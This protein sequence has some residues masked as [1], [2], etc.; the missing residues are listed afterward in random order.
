LLLGGFNNLFI[1]SELPEEACLKGRLPLKPKKATLCIEPAEEIVVDADCPGTTE[2]KKI[3]A[4]GIPADGDQVSYII[5]ITVS[6]ETV[7]CDLEITGGD[8]NL[9][10]ETSCPIDLLNSVDVFPDG[11]CEL[12]PAQFN[13]GNPNC[14]ST[15]YNNTA[16]LAFSRENLTEEGDLKVCFSTV[17]EETRIVSETLSPDE[18]FLAA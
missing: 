9:Q 7:N 13:G 12:L 5:P 8:L 3:L 15:L 1:P 11:Q 2:G 16:P 14:K 18:V 17:K 6:G 10:L 4:N